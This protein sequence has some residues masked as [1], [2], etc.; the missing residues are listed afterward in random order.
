MKKFIMQFTRMVF[1]AHLHV[2]YS[3]GTGDCSLLDFDVREE[4]SK[5]YDLAA[6]KM[7]E[8]QLAY[9]ERR[10]EKLP[11]L[12]LQDRVEIRKNPLDWV[13]DQIKSVA[14]EFEGYVTDY[15]SD[16]VGP[17]NPIQI[18]VRSKARGKALNIQ[19]MSAAY[20]QV[21]Y[22]GKR[23]IFVS[24]TSCDKL[25]EFLDGQPQGSSP[26]SISKRIRPRTS[27]SRNKGFNRYH[28]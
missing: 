10:L 23:P 9:D 12:T 6:K 16:Q 1:A 24:T 11:D 2:G 21:A 27:T 19:Q 7:T 25:I 22:G 26:L 5:Q 28:L 18:A 3:I 13:E 17:A 8:F 15:V 4:I 14:S 20:G